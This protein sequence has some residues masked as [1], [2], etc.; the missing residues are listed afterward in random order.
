M[1]TENLD[2]LLTEIDASPSKYQ[3]FNREG[4]GIVEKILNGHGLSSHQINSTEF[5]REIVRDSKR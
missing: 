3:T 1:F 4:M 2:L 5:L